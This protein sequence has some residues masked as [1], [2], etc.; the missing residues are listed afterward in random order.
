MTVLKRIAELWDSIPVKGWVMVTLVALIGAV[1]VATGMV[2]AAAPA[3][4]AAPTISGIPMPAASGITGAGTL[5]VS[6]GS[7]TN[8]PTGYA[9]QWQDCDATGANCHD[10]TGAG[11]TTS[12]YTVGV[13]DSSGTIRV[14]VTAQS[15]AGSSSPAMAITGPAPTLWDGNSIGNDGE[16]TAWD[17]RYANLFHS[18]LVNQPW[19]NAVSDINHDNPHT[20]VF[21]YVAGPETLAHPTPDSVGDPCRDY[22]AAAAQAAAHPG[23]PRYDWFLYDSAHN[24]LSFFNP[25]ANGGSTEYAMDPGNTAY[26]QDCAQLDIKRAI[27]DGLSSSYPDGIVDDDLNLGTYCIAGDCGLFPGWPMVGAQN[28]YTND[29]NWDQ[30]YINEMAIFQ[31]AFHAAG[32]IGPIPNVSFGYAGDTGNDYNSLIDNTD[33]SST[34]TFVPASFHSYPPASDPNAIADGS[35]LARIDMG[36]YNEAHNKLFVATFNY[37]S[38]TVSES[39][40]TF[41]MASFLME[42]NGHSVFDLLPSG[43]D[44]IPTFYPSM[45]DAMKLGPASGAFTSAGHVYERSFAN[46]IAVVNASA[47][48]AGS[49]SLPGS[50]WGRECDAVAGTCQTLTNASSVSLGA[51]GAAVLLNVAPPVV[52]R[53]Q[54]ELPSAKQALPS[55]K[56]CLAKRKL[57]LRLRTLTHRQRGIVQI[58][59]YVNGRH[60]LRER[61]HFHNVTLRR[62]PKKGKVTIKIVATTK[63]H[64]HLISRRRYDA[65]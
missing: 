58:D 27:N 64:Y 7:W 15:A 52:I 1:S 62:L 36:L 14:Q 37:P 5:T 18:V 22:S 4:T 40:Q 33:G 53:R 24:K 6:T 43:N 29:N 8:N 35:W 65:C 48:A 16:T 12:T 63:R 19:P 21:V 45:I 41:A 31:R 49:V 23:D 46:G 10:A 47:S 60:R 11:A 57:L 34:Q 61:R 54:A 13:N 39:K 56:A 30:A 55:G 32:L 50:F 3:N 9:Y 17:N 25:A 51:F 59:V 38:A 20:M 44:T 2:S 42:A 28:T 26:A